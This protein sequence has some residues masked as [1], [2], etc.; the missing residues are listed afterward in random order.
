MLRRILTLTTVLTALSAP[1]FAGP[2]VYNNG[3]PNSLSGNEMT[4]W[5]QAEDF[6]LAATTDIGDV[7]FWA[8][9]ITTGLTAYQGSI[10]WQIY[11]NAAG[12]PGALLAS[13]SASPTPVFDHLHSVGSSFAF[14]FDIPTFTAVGGTR[15]WLGLHNGPLTTDNLFVLGWETTAP[16]GT[17]LGMEDRTPFDGSWSGNFSEHAFYLTGVDDAAAVPEPS[18]LLLIGPGFAALARRFRRRNQA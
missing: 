16:N 18:T 14:D 11:A 12:Q 10:T 7:H 2:I 8:H 3:A 15:Y 13:G 17:S 4:Q 5:I 6:T 9:D 1:S